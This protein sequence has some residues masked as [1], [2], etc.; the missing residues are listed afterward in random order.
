MM[1][2]LS[3]NNIFFQEIM[4]FSAALLTIK[5]IVPKSNYKEVERVFIGSPNKLV[6]TSS[7]EN[8]LTY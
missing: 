2:T 6:A 4:K 7:R 8:F 1:K 3:S 5:D